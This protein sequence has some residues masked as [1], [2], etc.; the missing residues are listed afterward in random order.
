MTGKIV[1]FLRVIFKK[2]LFK[3]FSFVN[4]LCY[5]FIVECK[6]CVSADYEKGE[7]RA[8]RLVKEPYIKHGYHGH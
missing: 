3:R 6:Y 1:K 5:N 4:I 7:P 2:C 8:E